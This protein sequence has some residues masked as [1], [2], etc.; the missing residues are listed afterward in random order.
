[1]LRPPEAMNA[2]ACAKR[3]L[4]RTE[5]FYPQLVHALEKHRGKGLWV[6]FTDVPK[7]GIKTNPAHKDPVG[8]YFFPLDHIADSFDRY[9]HWAFRK[10]VFVCRVDA[11]RILD[12]SSVTAEEADSAIDLS[13][14]AE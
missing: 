5:D 1:L 14:V 3:L 12:L 4:A 6:H 8:V 2:I 7:V 9:H 10:Y 11:S 13:S